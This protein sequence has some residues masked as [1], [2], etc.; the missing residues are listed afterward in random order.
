MKINIASRGRL[1]IPKSVRDQLNLE[2][3][4]TLEL[5]VR[6]TELVLRPLFVKKN[7]RWVYV[8]PVPAGVNLDSL[9]D[10]MR[11]QRM[12]DILNSGNE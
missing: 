12:K 7:G 5:E 8:G 9:V 11:E 10:D 3:G 1:T 6:S 2:P 4:S